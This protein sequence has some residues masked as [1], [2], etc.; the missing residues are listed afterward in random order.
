MAIKK[1]Y[2]LLIAI[3][4]IGTGWITLGGTAAVLHYTSSEKFCISCH[5][6]ETP[7]KEYQGSVHY[8]NA[9]GIRAE[10]ADCHIPSDPIGYVITKIRAT[11]DIYHEFITGKIDTPEKYEAHRKELAETVWAQLK[12]N[13]SATCRSCHTFDAME[14]YAQS[15]DAQK[16]HTYAEENNQ[17]CIDCH[18]GVAHLTPEVKLDDGAYKK[19]LALTEKTSADAKVVYPVATISIGDLGSISPTAPLEVISNNGKER[20]FVLHAY[21][22]KGAEQV[23]YMG[24]GQ[25]SVLA[26]LSTKGQKSLKV[27]TYKTDD[28]GNQWRPVTL[29]AQT[30]QPVV[31]SLKPVWTYAEELDNVYCST[32][33]SKIPP[34]H[35][36]VNAWGPV[37][38]T[39]GSRTDITPENLELLTKFFQNHAKDITNAKH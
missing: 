25:R 3:I 5:T 36:T 9:Y 19:L 20:K 34:K 23:L 2:V 8:S 38:K 14:I 7:F 33:H 4:G 11:K 31:D 16:M 21:Q 15:K 26:Q 22:M 29:T 17:T 24:E 39:M 6:M 30:D 35:F 32:C 1:R 18:K 13:D 27:G 28:Y 10:C 12:A 37:A